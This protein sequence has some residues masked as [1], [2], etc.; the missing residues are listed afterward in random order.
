MVTELPDGLREGI[1]FRVSSGN[2]FVRAHDAGEVVCKLRG[3]LKKELVYSTSDS[4]AKRVDQARK[5][6][7]TDP[8]AVGDRV[9]I[10]ADLGMI[11]EIMPRHSELSRYASGQRGQ[12]V[13]VANL[14]QFYVVVAADNPPPD[15]WLMDRFLVMAEAAEIPCG[16]LVNK[17]DRVEG[18]ETHVRAMAALYEKIGYPVRC[19]SAK[20][21]GGLDALREAL[22]GRISAFAG[23]SGVGKSSLLNA[24]QPGL[25]LKTAQNEEVLPGGRHTTTTA[26]LIPWPGH[27]DTWVADTP[28]LRQVE[29]WEVDRDDIPFCFPEFAP[30][31]PECRFHNC[32][33]HTELGCAVRA[34][35]DEGH[36]DAHRYQSYLQ[37]T[38]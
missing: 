10:D 3:N 22:L 4:R 30:Y 25:R 13:L 16:V 36:I 28:G 18:D 1:V 29:F 12:H 24:L 31:L 26:E 19:V 32:R 20:R 33:H 15:L 38:D 7:S 14:D 2:Y 34:A 37:M 27:D 6:R 9:R 8:I 21:G 17:M 23:P 5:R 11:E 35:V